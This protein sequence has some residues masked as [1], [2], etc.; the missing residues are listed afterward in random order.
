MQLSLNALQVHST[1]AGR[2]AQAVHEPLQGELIHQT[3]LGGKWKSRF[4]RIKVLKSNCL[5][6][7]IQS[8]KMENSKLIYFQPFKSIIILNI[9]RFDL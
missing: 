4:T 3:N 2:N 5:P 9:K 7:N 6:M 8:L 1:Y